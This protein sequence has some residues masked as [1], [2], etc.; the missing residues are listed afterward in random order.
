MRTKSWKAFRVSNIRYTNA[1]QLKALEA[2]DRTQSVA[3]TIRKLGYPGR[4]R[5]HRWIRQ[6]SEPPSSSIRRTTLKSYPFTTKL[7][8]V[9]LFGS[10]MSPDAVAAEL[11]LNLKM[12]V[13]AWTQR[14][15]E[16]GKWGLTSATERKQSA[17]IVTRKA[18]EKSLP[19]DVRHSL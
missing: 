14:F 19:D 6:R 2:F 12:S 4:Y 18:L 13:Y 8:A 5:L 11:S 7:K 3:K 15:R 16:E 9:E 17:G 10:G 1:H